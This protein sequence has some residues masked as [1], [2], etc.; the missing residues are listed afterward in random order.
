MPRLT[1]SGIVLSLPLLLRSVRMENLA[2]SLRFYGL[3]RND[4]CVNYT[5]R[6]N[7]GC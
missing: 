4:V 7:V 6:I 5:E 2:L 1:I 3:F